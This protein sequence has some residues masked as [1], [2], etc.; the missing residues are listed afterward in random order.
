MTKSI[1]VIDLGSNTA[2]LVIYQQDEQGN[3]TEVD[4]IKRSLRLSNHL[5]NNRLDDDGMAIT[6]TCLR[7]FKELLDARQVQQTIGV[8][9]AAVRQAENGVEL[10]ERIKAEAGITIQIL[11]GEEEARY[12]YLAVMDSMNV[13]EGITID[14]GGGSTE[15]T[16]FQNRKLK[17]SHSFPFGI[18]TLTKRF[19]HS[20]IPTEAEFTQLRSFLADS[21]ASKPWLKNKQCPVIAIG[22]TAR[23]LGKIH[24]R[25]VHYSMDS[26]HHYPISK[27]NV[28]SILEHIRILSL[29]ERRQ[30]PGMSKDRADVVLSGIAAFESLLSYTGSDVLLISNKGLREGVLYESVWGAEPP[31]TGSELHAKTAAQF[32]NRYH[33]DTIHAQHVK[34]LSLSLFDQLGA[35][36]LHAFGQEERELLASASLLHDAGRSINVYESSEHTFYLLSQ[37]LM[38]G[39]THR[40]RL[41]IAMLASYKSNKLLLGQISRHADIVSKQDKNLIEKLGT[42]LL[43]S[44]MLDRSMTQSIH[45]VQLIK[46]NGSY[47]LRCMGK[48][49]DHLEYSLLDEPLIKFSKAWKIPIAYTAVADS[50]KT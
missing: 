29:E 30:V 24:Q 1:G 22:G 6:L 44:R 35:Q 40:E 46:T 8:A 36:R 13:D 7:Q 10:L 27:E 47:L 3:L 45:A 33:I 25:S 9:T 11:T 14:I 19:L 39:F 2:R 21:F 34:S 42:L 23:N 17:E 49:T 28:T 4:N 48:R 32:M 5:Q 31:A 20:D 43:V 16:Y 15:V 12:G 37:V 41:L 38:A 18:V 26:L 50:P